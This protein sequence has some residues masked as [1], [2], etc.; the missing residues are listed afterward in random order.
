MLLLGTPVRAAV[1]NGTFDNGLVGWET[2][3]AIF[4]T[5]QLGV[6]TD[7]GAPRAVLWQMVL[8][9]PGLDFLEFDVLGSL[10]GVGGE[11]TTLFASNQIRF[12]NTGTVRIESGVLQPLGGFTRSGIIEGAGTL[13]ASF[14]N[15]RIT[16]LL[17]TVAAEDPPVAGDFAR[18]DDTDGDGLLDPLEAAFGGSP[19]D[20]S[21]SSWMV[22]SRV[23]S[24]TW[25]Q[26]RR[27]DPCRGL[28]RHRCQGRDLRLS[29]RRKPRLSRRRKPRNRHLVRHRES[30]SSRPG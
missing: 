10:A 11:E 2:S 23:Q 25:T 18:L 28:A 16:R 22:G 15:N 13:Q 14:T 12:E 9:P 19:T 5:G 3:G 30:P 20:P 1:V 6:I 21:A 17:L 24:L 27:L 4:P 8:L 29:R 26:R 7:Q